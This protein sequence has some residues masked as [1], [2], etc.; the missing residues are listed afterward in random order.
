MDEQKKTGR[1]VQRCCAGLILILLVL[2]LT[3]YAGTDSPAETK[4]PETVVKEIPIAV[5]ATG[6]PAFGYR[7]KEKRAVP[8][9]VKVAGP[10][11]TLA[12]MET[13]R[14]HSIDIT[15]STNTIKQESAL[16]LPEGIR[17]VQNNPKVSATIVIEKQLVEKTF[18]NV[19]IQTRHAVFPS[20]IQPD[21]VT[22]TLRTSVLEFSDSFSKTDIQAYIDLKGLGPGI[23]VKPAAIRLPD[24]ARL[25]GVE[26]RVF[27]LQ[28]QSPD[29]PE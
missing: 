9:A 8:A 15:G 4:S 23:Y 27:T 20:R 16:D 7:V 28:I 2:P 1:F 3:G 25:V 17:C 6:S 14:T 18:E 5:F 13:A 29:K 24:H 26:P 12:R 21:T 11:K 22:V 19:P 10:E